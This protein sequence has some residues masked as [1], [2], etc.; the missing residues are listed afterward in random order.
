V[1]IVKMNDF[2]NGSEKEV[3]LGFE[4]ARS[5]DEDVLTALIGM[6]PAQRFDNSPGRA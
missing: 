2:A 1:V 6:D 3:T 5:R 4:A